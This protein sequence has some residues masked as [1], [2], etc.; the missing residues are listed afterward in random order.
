MKDR[1]DLELAQATCLRC[2]LDKGEWSKNAGHGFLRGG[3]AYCCRDCADG[4]GCECGR[5]PQA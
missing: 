2:G 1:I 4:L 3:Q 5:E